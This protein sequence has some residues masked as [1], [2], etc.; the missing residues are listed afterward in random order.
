MGMCWRSRGNSADVVA[1]RKCVDDVRKLISVNGRKAGYSDSLAA[2]LVYI[3]EQ[4]H[5]I[6]VWDTHMGSPAY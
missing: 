4:A 6:K 3:T 5:N 2:F 1:R